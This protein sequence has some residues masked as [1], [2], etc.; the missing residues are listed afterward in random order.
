MRRRPAA[1]VLLL[2]LAGIATGCSIPTQSDPNSIPASKVPSHLL[3]PQLPTTTM[4]PGAVVAEFT[5]TSLGI[6]V[7]T[8]GVSSAAGPCNMAVMTEASGA[9][10]AT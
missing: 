1:T 9:G 7:Y 4:L 2:V 10:D 8:P 5:A 6:A 3:D